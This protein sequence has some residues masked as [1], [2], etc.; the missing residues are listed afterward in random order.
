MVKRVSGLP[1]TQRSLAFSPDSRYLAVG[2]G[3][4]GIRV[5]DRDREWAEAFCDTNYGGAI[6]GL[7][8]AA[9]GRLATASYD[10]MVRLVQMISVTSLTGS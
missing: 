4:K 1:A 10:G 3:A 8:F 9:D 2:L 5:F 7:T 6:Y